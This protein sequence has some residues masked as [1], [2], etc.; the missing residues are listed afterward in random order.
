[1]LHFFLQLPHQEPGIEVIIDSSLDRNPHHP[2]PEAEGG[3][4]CKKRQK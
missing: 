4:L 3:D 1:M 2:Q